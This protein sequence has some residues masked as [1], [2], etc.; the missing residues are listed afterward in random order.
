MVKNPLNI[1]AY[2]CN[3]YLVIMLFGFTN[4]L[5]PEIEKQLRK[6][7]NKDWYPYILLHSGSLRPYTDDPDFKKRHVAHVFVFD[8]EGNHTYHAVGP[9]SSSELHKIESVIQ[10]E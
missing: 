6:N 2:D 9:Y 5:Q 10:S 4:M 7:F 8:K 3:V 1:E